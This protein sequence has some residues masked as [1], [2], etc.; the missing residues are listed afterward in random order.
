[1]NRM[2]S[3]LA[4]THPGGVDMGL[5]ALRLWFGLTMAFVHGIGKVGDMEAFTAAVAGLGFPLPGVL[6]PCAA[7]TEFIGGILLALGLFT[8]PAAAAL[9]TTMLVAAF[10]VHGDDPFMKKELALSFAVVAT[11]L[12]LTGP[13]RHS[14]DW[15]FIERPAVTA[16]EGG[17]A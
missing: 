3:A 2:L 10:V 4:G 12:I 1:M 6:A 14:G 9:L 7:V 13:G 8:R 17:D 11:A 15:H 16:A 5:L